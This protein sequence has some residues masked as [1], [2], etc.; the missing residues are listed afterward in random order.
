MVCCMEFIARH[1][2]N[3]KVYE[4]WLLDGV[5]DGDIWYGSMV[6][7]EAEWYAEPDSYKELVKTF[8]DCMYLAR[9]DGG[10]R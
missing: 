1:I 10:L 4:G 5:A 7:P 2:N 8:L 6:S 3:E 9:R